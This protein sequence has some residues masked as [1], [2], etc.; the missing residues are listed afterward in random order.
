MTDD[1]LLQVAVNAVRAE[2]SQRAH[3]ARLEAYASGTLDAAQVA[4]QAR[5]AGLAD[6]DLEAELA[7]FRPL[8]A[9]VRASIAARI[10][11]SMGPA[12][13]L[14]RTPVRRVPLQRLGMAVTAIALAASVG[15]FFRSRA[16]HDGSSLL[17]SY[18]LASVSGEQTWR[19]ESEP[20]TEHRVAR[21]D[22][23]RL[24]V[25]PSTATEGALEAR[26][27]VKRGTDVRAWP[28]AVEVSR[29][30]AVRIVAAAASLP[31]DTTGAWEMLVVVGRPGAMPTSSEIQTMQTA[32]ATRDVRIVKTR[33]TLD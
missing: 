26:V 31:A 8:D 28:S 32:D 25:R 29:A 5:A 18:E 1:E 14:R 20:T 15:L 7:G 12:V 6:A 22:R 23:M 10:Q 21:G 17:P 16:S 27:F 24:V 13:R 2:R 19:G 4:D 9:S 30:G 3:D 33:V 11:E